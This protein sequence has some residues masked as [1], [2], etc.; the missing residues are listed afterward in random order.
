MSRKIKIVADSKI[1]FLSGVLEPFAEI[2][3][4]NPKEIINETIKDADALIIR[5]RTK[6]NSSLLDNTNVRYISTATIGYDHID[7]EYCSKKNIKWINAPGCNSS[8][9]LQYIA[10]AL[11]SIAK[12]KNY[13]LSDLTLG[14]IGVGN[15]GSKVS[16]LAK[17]LG[18]N[19]LQND[20]PRERIEGGSDFVSID[21]L[22]SNSDIITFHTPLIKDGIDRTYHYADKS[23]FSKLSR[24]KLIINSSRGPVVE[25]SALK[26]AIKNGIIQSC[27][28][29]VWEKEPNIDR[30][31]LDLVDLGTPHIAGYSLDGKANGTLACVKGVSSFFNFDFDPEWYPSAIPMPLKPLDLIVDCE[32]REKQDILHEA[33]TYTYDICYDDQ[34]LRTAPEKFEEQRSS[35]PV[36]RE[37]KIF[38]IK[39]KNRNIGIQ[40][41]LSDIGFSVQMY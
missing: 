15:V 9:V 34:R 12:K 37:F 32:G 38:K 30:E 16:K 10:S 7:A 23:F 8:S 33:I 29:D 2:I 22:I 40:T 13:K 18:M 27:V 21:D 36:R 20:P 5:T 28:L 3:Y 4:L 24:T 35:Y 6:C 25:T 14:I 1:P 26:N 39:L 17:L 19:V 11:L 31:L 41:S